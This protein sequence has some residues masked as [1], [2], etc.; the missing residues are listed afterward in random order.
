MAESTGT[1]GPG[2]NGYNAS[3]DTDG[4]TYSTN[5]ANES[6]TSPDGPIGVPQGAEGNRS[7]DNVKV[8][9]DDYGNTMYEGNSM[10]PAR[11]QLGT[12]F[13]NEPVMTVD[14][15]Y[16]KANQARTENQGDY[17]A[18]ANENSNIETSTFGKQ[19]SIT[20]TPVSVTEN[21]AEADNESIQSIEGLN[22]E[23]K[24]KNSQAEFEARK[25]RDEAE[26]EDSSEQMRN[27][28]LAK[29]EE[30]TEEESDFQIGEEANKAEAAEIEATQRQRTEEARAK[31]EA[32]KTEYEKTK[33]DYE[34]AN[35]EYIA[36]EDEVNKETDNKRALQDKLSTTIRTQP[37][38]QN[39]INSIQ[40]QIDDISL[41]INTME[42]S[43]DSWKT[44]MQEAQA[45]MDALPAQIQEA[46][47]VYN[48]RQKSLDALEQ[49]NK[50]NYTTEMV[51]ETVVKDE[52]K[53]ETTETSP[54]QTAI[55]EIGKS[56]DP[57][58]PEAQEKLS[59]L[60]ASQNALVEAANKLTTDFRNASPE[61]I[62]A[63]VDAQKTYLQ[64]LKDANNGDYSKTNFSRQY[65]ESVAKANNFNVTLADG[66]TMTYADFATAMV[67]ES[68]TI[69]AAMYI[70][71]AEEYGDEHPV[72][73]AISRMKANMVQ[74][75]FGAKLLSAD[76]QVRSQ[77]NQMAEV[78]VRATYLAYNNVLSDPNATPEQKAEAQ[79][80]IAQANN[81]MTASTALKASTGFFS[82]IGDSMSDGTF[83]KTDPGALN[84]YQKTLNAISNFGKIALG[85]G[86][87]PGAN[88]AYQNMF[89]MAG[90]EVNRSF[91][92]NKDFDKD[93]FALCQEYG[94]NAAANMILG[95]GELA[96]GAAL[97]FN[98]ATTVLG[99]QML[100]DAVSATYDGLFGLRNDAGKSQ[101]YTEQV[102]SYFGEAI[103]L[104]GKSGNNEAVRALTS[105]ISQIE[106][107]KLGAGEVGDLNN[108]LEGSGSNTISNGKFNQSLSYDEWL[109]LIEADPTMQKYAKSL[110]AKKR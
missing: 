104:T 80:E 12:E 54:L 110:A 79:S 42:R 10:V 1:N 37:R 15:V 52:N 69:A 87:L 92:F 93:G 78:N 66:S 16:G 27:Q 23:Q 7:L 98:P 95:I 49:E 81:L 31:V 74:N 29:N 88:Q 44:Q 22:F 65:A 4:T 84:T 85:L 76:N 5:Q 107:F 47:A 61:D 60:E 108:W 109:K 94:N 30:Q 14:E 11:T 97:A 6:V 72:L 55:D 21:K 103:A 2:Y 48:Q 90:D 25:S 40:K 43:R 28:I 59:N 86:I 77:F 57:K 106:N 33:A 101:R 34:K 24:D 3:T 68:P 62:D 38:N 91:L 67:T 82:G 83:G 56:D 58:A 71:K 100:S 50:K 102:L 20:T 70:A 53:T 51:T 45:K 105:A 19:D 41:Q 26:A 18:F 9:V 32:L 46:E 39:L 8:G 64:N 99:L 96:T 63:Y 89:Y 75:W 35:D 36:Y 73:A 17:L 13:T